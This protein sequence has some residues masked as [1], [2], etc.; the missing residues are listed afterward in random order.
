[1]SALAVVAGES[2]IIDVM[3][4]ARASLSGEDL[5][6]SRVGSGSPVVF[7]H[8]S[9]VGARRAW[10]HQ[11]TLADSWMLSLPNRP[12][13]GT[14]PPIPRGD[15]EREAPMIAELLGD[16]AH[17]VGHSYGAV[18]AL[19]A[20]ALRPAAVRSLTVSEPGCL[21]VAA[22]DP[23]V[24]A[25]I[26]HGELL[27]E[28]AHTFSPLEFLHAFRGGVGSTHETPEHLMGELRQGVRLLMRERPPWEADP[29]LDALRRAAFPKLVISGGHSPVFEAVCD[30]VA[31]RLQAT[32]AVISGRGHTIPATGAPYNAR[33]HSFL[34]ESERE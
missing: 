18:I 10:R 27:F 19:Y 22:G 16:G 12:G 3:S 9:V 26:A 33:L 8:G 28:R 6:V 1:M 29:P 14:S 30:A 15:F 25:Q 7:V 4:N 31:D 32:R 2:T 13:F 5:D 21:R 20:A 17:L 11:L 24:D 23:R 34:T